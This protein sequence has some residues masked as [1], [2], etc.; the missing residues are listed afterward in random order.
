MSDGDDLE[1]VF[2]LRYESYRA[3]DAISK[4]ERRLM[5]DPFDESPNCVHVALE[6]DDKFV[7]AVRLHLVSNLA[8]QSPTLEVFPEIDA[9]LRAEKA[10]LDPTRFVVHP[11]ARKLGLPLHLAALRIPFLAAVYYD[12][13]I[14]LAA[15]RTEHSAFYQRY[16]GCDFVAPPRPYPMLKKPVGLMMTIMEESR[17]KVLQKYPF[18][19]VIESI[20]QSKIVFPDLPVADPAFQ[21]PAARVA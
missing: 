16:L 4:N 7:A 5:S 1:R 3:E 20:P 18:F 11:D 2:R 21:R 8:P 13:D 15:V 6:K 19:G 10:M 9:F 17:D 12:V 14:V